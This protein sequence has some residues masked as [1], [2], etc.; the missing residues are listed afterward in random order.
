MPERAVTIRISATDNFS[1]VMQRYNQAIGAAETTTSRMGDAVE[2]QQGSWTRF[3]SAVTGAIAAFG[4][5]GVMRVSEQMYTLGQSVNV[6]TQ[7]FDAL[8]RSVLGMDSGGVL[9]RMREA[10]GGI[11]TDFDLMSGANRLMSMGLTTSADQLAEMTA[12]AVRLGA[13]FGKDAKGAIED[14]SLMLAN[15]SILR[16]DTFGISGAAVRDRM[17]E[18]QDQFRGMTREQAFFQA[19]ME[20]MDVS[21]GR[22]GD[23]ALASETGVARLQ[24]RLQNFVNSAASN[25]A[26]GVNSIVDGF[27]AVQ[28]VAARANTSIADAMLNPGDVGRRAALGDMTRAIWDRFGGQMSQT[29]DIR[30]AAGA[31]YSVDAVQELQ[32]MVESAARYREITGEAATSIDDIREGYRDLVGYQA[33]FTRGQEDLVNRVLQWQNTSVASGSSVAG[34]GTTSTERGARAFAEAMQSASSF[35][36]SAAQSAISMADQWVRAADA[37]A[38]MSLSEV[39]GTGGGGRLGEITDQLMRQAGEQGMGAGNLEQLRRIF[40]LASGRETASSLAFQDMLLPALAQIGATNPYMALQAAQSYSSN[41]ALLAQMGISPEMIGQNTLGLAGIRNIQAG[42]R[43]LPGR[44]T[45]DAG[46]GIGEVMYAAEDAQSVF[47]QL[48]GST[49]EMKENVDSVRSAIEELVTNTNTVRLDFEIGNIPPLLAE[50]LGLISG[51]GLSAAMAGAT[52]DNGG[53]PPGSTTR[54]ATTTTGVG[55]RRTGTGSRGNAR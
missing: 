4:V 43:R 20:Q 2:R 44:A 10:T 47:E 49:S 51:G 6:A 27:T 26:V 11:I 29:V 13:A 12:G 17:A 38:R 28:D 41:A 48:A 33:E 53:T 5:A 55:T 31:P 36:A 39:F 42:T 14:F 8:S 16:L 40:D 32:R 52:R 46:E 24:T 7:N 9:Q 30:T 22:L 19:T 21:L 18:L 37:A 45:R 25:F 34:F 50:L 3:G 15:Q 1:S 54:S 35:I 23:A